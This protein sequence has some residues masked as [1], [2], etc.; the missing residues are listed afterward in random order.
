MNNF[1]PVSVVIPTFNRKTSLQQTIG[2]IYSCSVQPAEIIVVVDNNDVATHEMLLKTF[3]SVKTLLN[4]TV[5][6][7]GGSRNI[8]IHAAT[9]EWVAS[10]D[11]DSYP[12]DDD[13]FHV[14]NELILENANAAIIEATIFHTTEPVIERNNLLKTVYSFTGCGVVYNRKRFIANGGYVPIQP[15]YA[16]EETDFALRAF[17]NKEVFVKSGMLRVL[18][19]SGLEHHGSKKINAAVITN[20]F[21]LC[22]L[23]YPL[24]LWPYGFLQALNRFWW[25]IGQKRYAGLL[26]GMFN[27]VPAC[28]HYRK[29]RKVLP[30]KDIRLFKKMKKA[31]A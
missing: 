10:F 23:R 3:P 12:Y 15:A 20:T 24:W 14:L 30:G 11:D 28:Y 18:H 25:C 22:F 8:G 1:V 6:G 9:N 16:M 5:Q 7:P 19:D 4:T 2:R 29:Y 17:S 26:T 31:K 13:F 27:I 21:L